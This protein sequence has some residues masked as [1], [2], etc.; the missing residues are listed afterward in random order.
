[1]CGFKALFWSRM[2]GDVFPQS[3]HSVVFAFVAVRLFSFQ[4][5]VSGLEVSSDSAFAWR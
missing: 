1:M 5:N 3:A 2:L 4:F